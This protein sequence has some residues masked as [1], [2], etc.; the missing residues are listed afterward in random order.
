MRVDSRAHD[1]RPLWAR[2]DQ[3]AARRTDRKGIDHTI[4]Y[5]RREEILAMSRFAPQMFVNERGEPSTAIIKEFRAAGPGAILVS[6]SV[7]EGFDFPYKDA[8]WQFICKIPFP[9]SRA[10]IVKARQAD[11]PEYG[12][13]EAVTKLQQAAGR[14]M[15]RKDDQGETFIADDHMQWFVTRWGYLFNKTFFKFYRPVTV[16]PQPPARL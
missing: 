14:I 2:H 9:D 4:S 5:A 11:D 15:R 6:P 16:L 8:E 12:P 13:L 3:I 1:L 10:K 7:G